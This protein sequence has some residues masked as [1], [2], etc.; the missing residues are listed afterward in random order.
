MCIIHNYYLA[1]KN[2][3]YFYSVLIRFVE[4]LTNFPQRNHTQT[5]D[6]D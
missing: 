2:I 6:N 3:F 5:V 1:S 4:I